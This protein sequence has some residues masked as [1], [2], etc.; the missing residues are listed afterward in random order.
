M[1]LKG[2]RRWWILQSS[3]AAFACAL[4][5]WGASLLIQKWRID[6][7]RGFEVEVRRGRI[8]VVHAADDMGR[9][10][11]VIRFS[12]RP[13]WPNPEWNML[14]S[15]RRDFNAIIFAFP[16]WIPVVVTGILAGVTWI[17]HGPLHERWQCSA[18]GYDLRG[19]RA[20]CPECGQVIPQH[21][22]RRDA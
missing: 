4:L 3:A 5:V 6:L 14:P 2:S 12:G 20:N 19:G 15:M 1:T 17:R 7:D 21:R 10:F 11:L 13:S 9:V 16:F 18:C 8:E 22:Q